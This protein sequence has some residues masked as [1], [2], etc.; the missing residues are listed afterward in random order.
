MQL[1]GDR[2]VSQKIAPKPDISLGD[3]KNE[4]FILPSK[5]S[6]LNQLIKKI[7]EEKDVFSL[8]FLI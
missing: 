3:I 2:L 6:Y 7:C 4:N 5:D 8:I 1:R